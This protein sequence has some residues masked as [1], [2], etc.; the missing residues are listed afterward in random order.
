FS[1]DSD[2]HVASV[3]SNRRLQAT[4][5]DLSAD[6]DT[7]VTLDAAKYGVPYSGKR[8]VAGAALQSD[9]RIVRLNYDSALSNDAQ[10]AI[11][12]S[13]IAADNVVP[14]IEDRSSALLFG[15]VLKGD[16]TPVPGAELMPNTASGLQRQI[17]DTSGRFLFEYVPRDPDNGLGGGYTIEARAANQSTTVTGS[18]RLLHTIHRVNVVFLGRGSAKG[19]VR[20]E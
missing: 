8:A 20:Y 6:F 14:K 1:L 18:V 3:L 12:V 4:T 13:S 15:S 11:H 19:T 9:G 10:Y 5:A 2:G 17:A 16:N 7:D